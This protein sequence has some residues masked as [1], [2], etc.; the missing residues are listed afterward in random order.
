MTCDRDETMYFYQEIAL[1]FSLYDIKNGFYYN[2]RPPL[3]N[4]LCLSVYDDVYLKC[5]CFSI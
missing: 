2:H 3:Q 5:S 1:T 4:V